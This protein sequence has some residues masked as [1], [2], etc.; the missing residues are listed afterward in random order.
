M[1]LINDSN[2]FEPP[3]MH[4]ICNCEYCHI[5]DE[6]TELV[7]W[8]EECDLCR[9]ELLQAVNDGEFCLEHEEWF[10]EKDNT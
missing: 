9:K 7:E 10:C 4:E 3:D 5:E 8:A 1:H 6:H 2:H